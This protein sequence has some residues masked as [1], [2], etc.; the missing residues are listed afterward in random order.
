MKVYTFYTDSH[1]VILD[2]YFLKT[3]PKDD[4]IDLVIEKFN[5]DCSSGSFMSSGWNIT[6]HKKVELILRGIEEN[7]NKVFIHADCDIQFFD[8]FTDDCLNQLQDNDVVGQD[9]AGNI[10]CGF[11][12]IRGNEKTKAI[13]NE[14]L[15]SMNKYGNDQ[16]AFNKLRRGKIKSNVL[17]KRYMSIHHL[18]GC[19]VWDPSQIIPKIN[20]DIILHHANFV[21]GVENKIKILDGVRKQYDNS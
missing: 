17:N 18:N 2:N 16:I 10:C 1:K 9:D 14:V 12:V 19:K 8:S 6:M 13:F 4:N 20:K 7:F 15:N 3:L 5:Q 21:V 11:M